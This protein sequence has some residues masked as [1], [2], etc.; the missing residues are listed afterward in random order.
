MS[1]INCNY[2]TTKNFNTN[3][4]KPLSLQKQSAPEGFKHKPLPICDVHLSCSAA[5][6][7]VGF[8]EGAVHTCMVPPVGTLLPHQRLSLPKFRFFPNNQFITC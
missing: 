3:V 8:V 1:L 2:A 7:A 5:E 6:L 4:K